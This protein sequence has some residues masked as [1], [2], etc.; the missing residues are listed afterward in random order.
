MAP[1]KADRKS[2]LDAKKWESLRKLAGNL[3]RTLEEC[4]ACNCG[5]C[6]TAHLRLES[7]GREELTVRFGV[8]FTLDDYP[9]GWRETEITIVRA[10]PSR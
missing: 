10:Q 6:H 3:H 2:K 4:L 7:R 5:H 9:R 8:L 1:I